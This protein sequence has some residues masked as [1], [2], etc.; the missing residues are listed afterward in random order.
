MTVEDIELTLQRGLGAKGVAHLLSV[1][2]SAQA[3]YAA[4]KGELTGN[5]GLRE[6]IADNIVR[7]SCRREAESEMKYLSRHNLSGVASTDSGYP[8]LLSE[9]PDYPHVL[10]VRG[11]VNALQG[12]MVS[13]V[14]TRISSPYGQRMCDVL[15]GRL[16]EI[17][18]GTVIVSGLAYGI[19]A[20]AHRAALRYGLK[21][22]AVI[23]N[24]LP[25]VSPSQHRALAEEIIAA[26]GAI[27]SE[28][29]SQTKQNG[30]FF[31]PRNRIIAGMS[32][33]TIVVES[34]YKGGA[35]ETA[36]L[37]D[38][39][40]RNV[41]AVPGRVGDRSSDGANN[42]I[43]TRRA[44]MVCCG[45]DIVRELGW[46]ITQPGIIPERKRNIPLLKPD[47]RRIMECF[48][49]GESLDIDTLTMR[50]GV[51][52]GQ[53]AVVLLNLELGGIL[54]SLPGRI[55]ESTGLWSK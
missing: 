17:D 6:D 3:V 29:H 7:R 21:T 15:I 11:A 32:Q 52:A 13:V 35:L 5:A 26:G 10:Y 55:Y 25:E 24:P 42:L 4:G 19:D 37:A 41:M 54:R 43:V 18:S 49:E 9:C 27:V 20:S 44:A 1:M 22:V 50:S 2:G 28:L 45:D 36:K 16:A 30:S 51:P 53:L 38:G 48:G 33:G 47:E 23:A 40:E 31:I 46:D 12:R 34:P 39:Y 8:Q 14:G